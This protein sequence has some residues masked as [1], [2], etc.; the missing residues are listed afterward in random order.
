[1]LFQGIVV[2]ILMLLGTNAK[3]Q[4]AVTNMV[5]MAPPPPPKPVR[6][7]RIRVAAAVRVLLFLR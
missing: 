5:L 2:A 7:N 6:R 1:V 3:V 4:K